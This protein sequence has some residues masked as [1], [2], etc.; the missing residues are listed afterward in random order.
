MALKPWYKIVT[1][2]EDLREGKPLDAS[3]FAVHLE[4]V[5]DGRAPGVY[6]DPERF[7]ERTFLTKSLTGISTEVVRRLSGLK[8]ETS[9]VFN[10]TTQFGGGKTHALT[11]LY[12]LAN[13]GNA[14]SNWK[15]VRSIIDKAGIK[16]IPQTKTAVFVGTEFDSIAGRGGSDG[17]PLRKTP[18]GEIAFQLGGQKA[19]SFVAE[20]EEQ[21]IAPSSEII[22]KFLPEN[23]PALIL[24]D[25][26]MNY[27][28]RNRKSGL[29][30]QL[31]NF[32]QNLSEEV[33][34]HDNVVLAV[35]IPASE[36]EMTADDQTEYSRFK[37]LLD[38][39]GKAVIMSA[40]E[41]ISEIIR[42]RLFEWYGVPDEAKNV[43]S[44]YSDWIIG[45]RQ[46][47]PTWFSADNAREAFIASYPFHPTVLSVFQRKWQ[48]LPRFQQT[49]GVLRLLALWV[50]KAYVD[51]FKCAHKDP[52]I[53]IGTA[54]LDDPMFRS[55]VFEQLG[56]NRL[57]GPVTTDI[58]GKKEAFAVR[59]DKEA[60]E[61]IKKTRLHQKTATTVF[62]ESNGGQA[63]AEATLPE[64]RLAV[65]EPELD[66]GN[67]E[68]ALETL[69]TACYF[70]SVEKNKYRF[71][72]L[73]NLNKIL[74]DRKANIQPPR[75]EETVKAEIQKIFTA[76]QLTSGAVV[77]KNFFPEK[78]NQISDRAVLTF[79]I[80]AP[81]PT[82]Q[83]DKKLLQL[84]DQLSR[85][86]GTSARTFKSALIWCIPDA[87]GSLY[88]EA[89]ILLAW[90]D[91]DDELD[92]LHLD[93]SQKRQLST[94]QK[95][96]E[97]DLKE[98]V[99]RTY[100]RV[101]LLGKNNDWLPIEFGPSHSSAAESLTKLI[102]DR[103]RRENQIEESPSP[104][105]LIRNWPPAFIEWSSK[106]VKDT[107]FASPQFP[108]LLNPD[109]IKETIARG[110]ENGIIGYLGKT[111]DGQYKPF[112][113]NTSLPATDIEISEDM[114]IVTGDEAKKHVEPPK[115]TRLE[116]S[117]ASIVL[118]P[119]KAQGFIV[120]G[121]DQH[122]RNI[123]V[124]DFA[125]QATGGTID[126][127]GVFTAG[128]KEGQ[129]QVVAKAGNLSTVAEITI[130]KEAIKPP[131]RPTEQDKYKKI[132][133]Q[134]EI[135]PQKW[136]NFYT[137]VLAKYV[138]SGGVKVGLDIE[139]A[140]PEGISKQQV[141]EIK[142]ALRE[143]GLNDNV[144]CE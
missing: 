140:P 27:I 52:L 86:Y 29:A 93:E 109:A 24:V 102:L 13:G 47:I 108:R 17:T 119:K 37:K 7:F 82:I 129:F 85:E 101:M 133:W 68:T 72:L 35:S 4:Q 3:E 115:L 12:H 57:E 65:A 64:I 112:Y 95:K 54:P 19:F 1:P 91:I 30:A 75:I 83:D 20:H 50:S 58:V 11:L 124:Q 107:F 144:S 41:E 131:P 69:T 56:E 103:L 60:V 79:V 16:N 33:R 38:R 139:I 130:S 98:A 88:E 97:R 143:L 59:L 25:E 141:E 51:G 118:K 117:P 15:G 14:A 53:S 104:N 135:Q 106:A 127:K 116:I 62:F 55:A 76:G 70:L 94:N 132:S 61:T 89:R 42:R 26:L 92:E 121:Y 71:S 23:E 77:E 28:S 74:S 137:K 128:D 2:R 136:M 113:Y 100:S 125:W 39:L 34:G 8:V 80:L 84:I 114:F 45:H 43:A 67:V 122:N 6:Q 31:Y 123:A 18:W 36:L 134:G 9:P 87:S 96:A 10:M 78:S 66:I 63:R 142:V 138:T 22:R 105:F 48:A 21:L 90:E 126:D 32:I 49:R 99:W 110:V 120:K 5:R 44:A 46:Q 111:A 73:P 40:E 81:D